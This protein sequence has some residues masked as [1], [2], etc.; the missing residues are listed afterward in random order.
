MESERPMARGFRYS[1][2][3]LLVTGAALIA[4]S[5]ATGE[6]H[7]FLLVFI[8]VFTSTGPLGLLG[9]VALFGGIFL[10]MLAAPLGEFP[11]ESGGPT[12]PR[13]PE[14]PITPVA[15]SR[16]FGGVVM[17]GPIPIVFGSDARIAKWM[18]VLGFLLLILTV[19][20]WALL[21]LR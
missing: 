1:G 10:A 2:L 5:V 13:S 9:I 15:P 16:R 8:P 4:A 3:A 21:V 7:L 20:A 19:A 11:A 18:L 6:G 17:L 12:P 14:P